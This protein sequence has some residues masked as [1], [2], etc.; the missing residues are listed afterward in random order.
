[1]HRRVT[2]AV[3]C[4]VTAPEVHGAFRRTARDERL[5]QCRVE[6]QL[7]RPCGESNCGSKCPVGLE[8]HVDQDVP[9]DAV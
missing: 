7:C 3:R 8:N 1:M 5:D 4:D 9:A 6:K 2:R